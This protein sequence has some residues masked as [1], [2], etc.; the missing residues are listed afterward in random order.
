MR[1]L[2]GVIVGAGLTAGAAFLHD[3]WT[4]KGTANE[5]TATAVQSRPMVNWDVVNENWQMVGR[6]AR[7]A[8]TALSQ[9]VAS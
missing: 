4:V 2:F 7:E 3:T 6:R 5:T 8:W 1:F 9:K